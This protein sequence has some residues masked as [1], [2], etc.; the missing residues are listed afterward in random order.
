M[1]QL[2]L[3]AALFFI[4]VSSMTSCVQYEE[5]VYFRKIDKEENARPQFPSDTIQN[6]AALRIQKNDVLSITVHSFDPIQS[7]PFNLMQPGAA[8]GAG[9]GTASPF[10]SYI[11]D[12]NG[13][14]DFPVLGKIAL[15]DLTATEAKTKLVDSLKIYLKDPVVNIRFVNFRV[16]VLG[17]VSNPGIFI[18][19][20]DRITVLEVLSMAGDLTD[21]GNR[22][23]ILVVREQDGIRKYGELN[24]QSSDIF[25]S[26]FYYLKQGDV[27]YIE[28]TENKE[29]AVRDQLGEYIPWISAGISAV[30]A[31]IN[32]I[33]LISR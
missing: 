24:L 7:A 33:I 16:S 25:K 2:I 1:K 9:G 10:T 17:E 4:L 5:L 12:E 31:T 29:G 8:G 13:E 26:E 3:K 30:T 20:N 11:V 23:N 27:V 6:L 32:L 28:P 14:I 21:Y 18:I 15:K 22:T 19:N